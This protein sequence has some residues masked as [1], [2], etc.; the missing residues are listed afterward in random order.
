MMVDSDSAPNALVYK[1]VSLTLLSFIITSSKAA[2]AIHYPESTQT[3]GACDSDPMA[4]PD[5]VCLEYI[6]LRIYE[7]KIGR[8]EPFDY[9]R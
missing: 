8:R 2:M 9:L 6:Y 5:R 3:I 1:L 7:I 4:L